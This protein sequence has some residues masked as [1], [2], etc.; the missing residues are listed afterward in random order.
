ML[1]SLPLGSTGTRDPATLLTEI[2][3]RQE[4][5]V[6]QAFVEAAQPGGKRRTGS[7]DKLPIVLMCAAVHAA[8]I[9]DAWST[10]DALHHHFPAGY[11]PEEADPIMRPFAGGGALYPMMNLVFAVPFDILLYE[12]RRQHVLKPARMLAYGAASAWVGIELRQ[13][14]INLQ[15]EHIGSGR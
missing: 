1:S 5:L 11:H 8:V 13:S 9:F 2:P 12:T 14:V 15:A 4:K 6:D 10:N 3:P 7:G